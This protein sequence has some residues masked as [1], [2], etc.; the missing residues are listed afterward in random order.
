MAKGIRR[1]RRRE[2]YWRRT[3]REQRGSGQTIR[4]FCRESKLPESAFYFWRQELGRRG[5]ERREAEQEQ[6]RPA[7]PP[8]APAFVP[9]RVKGD[10]AAATGG[11][12]EIE[13]SGGRRVHVVAPIDR[14]VLADVLTVLEERHPEGQAC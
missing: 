10:G 5:L 9:V 3:I 7:D 6:H 13:L 14:Q 1:D 11:R 8:A 12:I 2:A 4:E